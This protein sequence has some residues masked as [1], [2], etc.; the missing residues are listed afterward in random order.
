LLSL[1]RL[2]REG[3]GVKNLSFK[4]VSVPAASDGSVEERVGTRIRE[5]RRA[6][7]LTSDM[8]A[9]QIGIS[10]DRLAL[11]ERGQA[12][13]AAEEL[14]DIACH[15]KRTISYFFSYDRASAAPGK[16]TLA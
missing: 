16:S 3:D 10:D 15:L 1:A 8:L 6:H 4:A 7:G 2:N 9:M 12:R 13:I 11:V 5:G 14:F